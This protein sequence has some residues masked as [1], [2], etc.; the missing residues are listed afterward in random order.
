MQAM[1]SPSNRRSS[2]AGKAVAEQRRAT[3]DAQ[4]RA[5]LGLPADEVLPAQLGTVGG[6]RGGH[7]GARINQ[8]TTGQPAPWHV[9]ARRNTARTRWNWLDQD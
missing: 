9:E 6:S 7:N 3:R 1:S 4:Y 8:G 2:T 5:A